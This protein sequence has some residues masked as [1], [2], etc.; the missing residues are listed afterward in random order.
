VVKIIQNEKKHPPISILRLVTLVGLA[1]YALHH[2]I[3][4]FWFG[5]DADSDRKYHQL[6]LYKKRQVDIQH[7]LPG[8]FCVEYIKYLLGIQ[9]AKNS[10]RGCG[11]TYLINTLLLRAAINVDSLLAVLPDALS[12]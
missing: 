5:A 6:N 10:G 4:I 9:R 7:H 1:A 3:V 8:L 12:Y 2:R 11:D